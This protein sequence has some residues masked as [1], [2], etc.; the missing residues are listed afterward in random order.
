MFNNLNFLALSLSLKSL[1]TAQK[2]QE[3]GDASHQEA[4]EHQMDLKLVT[5][6]AKWLRK[7]LNL[8]IFGFDVVV[9]SLI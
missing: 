1:P 7:M 5:D 9:S 8:T 3:S 4:K 6:A 2:E